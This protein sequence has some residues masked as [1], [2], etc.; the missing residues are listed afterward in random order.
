MR[1]HVQIGA[2]EGEKVEDLALTIKA[3]GKTHKLDHEQ[4]AAVVEGLTPGA[5][6]DFTVKGAKKKAA[7][8]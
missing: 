3:K 2:D 8:A 6:L 7:K 1:L 4:G 5:V